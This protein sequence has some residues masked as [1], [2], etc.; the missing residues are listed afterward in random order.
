MLLSLTLEKH[1]HFTKEYFTNYQ[2]KWKSKNIYKAG[3]PLMA[4]ELIAGDSPQ[5]VLTDIY[6]LGYTIKK[7]LTEKFGGSVHRL[8]DISLSCMSR[9]AGNRLGLNYF[10]DYLS[11]KTA[12]CL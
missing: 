10:I 8:K 7:V 6:S 12:C 1:A 3:Y 11:R 5:N 4:P 2:I 9:Q